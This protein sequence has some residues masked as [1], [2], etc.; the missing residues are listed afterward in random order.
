MSSGPVEI[1]CCSPATTESVAVVRD[2]VADSRA[3]IL[4]S[5]GQNTCS[6][7]SDANVNTLAN[8]NALRNESERIGSQTDRAT[9]GLANDI[10]RTQSLVGDNFARLAAQGENGFYRTNVGINAGFSDINNGIHNSYARISEQHCDIKAS[11]A[12]AQAAAAAGH[13]DIKTHIFATQAAS[14][15]GHSDLK[16]N[17]F[18]TQAASAAAH[19]DIKSAI[20]SAQSAAAVAHCELKHDIFQT[21]KE[22]G[23]Q[24]A[25]NFS[26]LQLQAALNSKESLLEQSKWFS[27]AERLAI[28]NKC[29]LEAKMAAC[30]CE[31]KEAVHSTASATQALIQATETTRIRDALSAATTENTILKLRREMH[32]SHEHDRR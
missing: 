27:A 22:L 23:L 16:T 29:E 17:I 6:I 19:C 31:L 30:C 8:I 10:H 18:A 13:S 7:L 1:P 2:K 32:H 15:A 11:V 5:N 25:Q 28:M 20:A 12:A 4:L 14:A 26:T 21:G 9:Y 3:D 24:S